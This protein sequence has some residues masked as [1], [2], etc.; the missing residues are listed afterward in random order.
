ME[1]ILSLYVLQGVNYAIPMA[2]LPFL[3]RVLGMEQYGLIAFAQ[4]IAQYFVLFTDYGFNFTASRAITQKRDDHEAVS[5]IFSAVLLIKLVLMVA[6]IIVMAAIVEG[7]PRFRVHGLL[8]LA[9]YGT[10]IGNVLFP[11]WY[12]QGTEQMRYISGV[13]SATR[14]LGAGAL[15]LLVRQPGDAL[16]A[17]AIQSASLL[18]GG[19]AGLGIAL[20]KC[21]VHFS[22]PSRSEL[23][24]TLSEGW[25]LFI[26][27]A[28]VSLYTNTSVF[29]VG[30]MCGNL[31][32]GYFSSAEK[33]IRA[34]QGLIQ[35]ISQAL[36]PQVNALAARSRELAL[37]LNARVLAWTGSM[38]LAGSLVLAL[39]A[40]PIALLCFGSGAAGMVPV[41]RWVA[42]IPFLIGISN[43]LGIQTMVPFGLDRA[44]SRIIVL[45]GL[46]NLTIALPLIA[47]FAA[48]GAGM[49]VLATETL[50]TIAMLLALR[51]HDLWFWSRGT[52]TSQHFSQETAAVRMECPPNH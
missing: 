37:R 12:F 36:F 34:M 7:V 13:M 50:V 46:F 38:T 41:L 17:V 47:V 44:F 24:R 6:G 31:Q 22:R 1:S 45:A 32:A 33:L 39:A 28:A 8:F 3:V 20:S 35:P 42:F 11:T 49:S 27:S 52:R 14:L 15:F 4:S 2:I 23:L 16:L 29:L 51:Y 5:R 10:V 19:L 21:K 30:L 9:A 43:I 48:R 40:H 18:I 26:S 25:N